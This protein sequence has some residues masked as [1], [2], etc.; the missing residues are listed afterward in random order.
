MRKL[1]LL[2]CAVIMTCSIGEAVLPLSY[3]V[4]AAEQGNTPILPIQYQNM[5]GKGMDVDWSKT[6][7]GRKYY[8][9]TAVKKFK[10]A[11]IS[12]VRIRVKDSVSEKLFE[13]LDKQ[14]SDCIR[15]GLMPVLAY[16]ADEF[17]NYVTDEKMESAVDWWKTVAEHYKDYSY[18][19]AFDLLIECSDAL[20]KQPQKLNEYYERAVSAIRLT[21]PDRILMM[22]PRVRSD[23]SYL[24]ELEIPTQANG[25]M[26]AEWHFYASGPSKENERKL[27][28]TGT[29][30]EK[31]L[32]KDKISLALSWQE[33]TGIP[34]WVGAWMAGNY[35]DGDDYS[36]EEQIRFANYMVTQLEAAKIPFAVNSD[37]KFY[38][39]EINEW[40]VAMKPLRYC[41]FDSYSKAVD[42]LF[43]LSKVK[44][45]S[46]KAVS[47]N[48]IQVVWEKLN[49]THGY[50]LLISTTPKFGKRSKQ[51]TVSAKSKRINNLQTGKAYYI[52]VRGYRKASGQTTYSVYSR[53]LKIKLP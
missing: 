9:E 38:N 8:S 45:S 10:Q 46:A 43:S 42:M 23:A 39:R 22:S 26:M 29:A 32:I 12:H 40:I 35:N 25:Y 50:K 20:N 5:L 14:I 53:T 11:G 3:Q 16:Q 36:M 18:L 17:K 4:Y 41:I 48:S 24:K 44:L 19:L 49:R 28:T 7:K 6:N 31:Q 33:E 51:Y 13:D 52:K 2:V 15:Y 27:W 37:T 34:T 21:N 1:L 30:K 47:K